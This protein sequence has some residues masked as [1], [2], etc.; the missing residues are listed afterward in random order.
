[1]GQGGEEAIALGDGP[2]GGLLGALEPGHVGEGGADPGDGAILLAQGEFQAQVGARARGVRQVDLALDGGAAAEDLGVGGE[3]RGRE[4][5]GEGL[6]GGAPVRVAA[7]V[8]VEG[9]VGEDAA[10]LLVGDKDLE[11]QVLE[12]TGELGLAAAGLLL[13]AAQPG[14]VDK[15]EDDAVDLGAAPVGEDPE[16][17]PAVLEVLDVLLDG[18]RPVADGPQRVVEPGAPQAVAEGLDAAPDVLGDQVEDLGDA[19]CEPANLQVFRA[20]CALV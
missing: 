8:V 20:V 1:M 18:G 9:V 5:G 16:Q 19:G 14:H 13:G 15:G 3:E 12:D 11:R 2:L 17:V 7:E 6:L 10:A 4:L